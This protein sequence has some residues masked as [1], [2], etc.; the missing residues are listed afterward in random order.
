MKL[1]TKVAAVAAL[2]VGVTG[3]ASA[4]TPLRASES[5]APAGAVSSQFLALNGNFRAA[6]KMKKH[7]NMGAETLATVATGVSLATSVATV[8]ITVHNS[9]K[10]DDLKKDVEG[11]N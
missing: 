9:N 5:V 4:A 10:I 7:A 1:S 2:T 6:K 11:T 3:I 8:A